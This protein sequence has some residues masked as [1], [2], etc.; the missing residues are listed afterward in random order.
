MLDCFGFVTIADGFPESAGTSDAAIALL[1]IFM[2]E[3]QHCAHIESQNKEE[4]INDS[5]FGA[6]SWV[7]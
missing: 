7:D 5:D 4:E 6:E 2:K 1:S 3:N